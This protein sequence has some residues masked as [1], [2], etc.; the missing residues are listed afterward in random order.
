MRSK[1]SFVGIVKYLPGFE[2]P[3]MLRGGQSDHMT[4]T[5]AVC[6]KLHSLVY[7]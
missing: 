3:R 6:D 4:V 7:S 5:N 2:S 1:T